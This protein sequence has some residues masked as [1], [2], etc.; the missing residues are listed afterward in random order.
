MNREQI[1][2]RLDDELASYKEIDINNKS[3]VEYVSE[4][5]HKEGYIDALLD[6]LRGEDNE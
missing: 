6:V 1:M 4:I 2:K 3:V 5:R